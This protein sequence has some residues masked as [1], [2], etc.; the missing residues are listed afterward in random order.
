MHTNRQEL[1]RTIQWTTPLTRELDEAA[2]AAIIDLCQSSHGTDFTRLF[3]FL[4]DDGWHVIGWLAGRPICHAVRTTRW[5]QPPG[6]EPLKTA[7][8]DAVSTAVEHQGKGL[9]SAA[10]RRLAALIF[11]ED[12]ALCAL[13]TDKAG[14]YTRLGWEVWP[15]PLGGRR[16]GAVIELPEA[17]GNVLILRTPLTPV[18]DTGGLLTIEDQGRF[19]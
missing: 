4:P 12:Y 15:G 10:M 18:L 3:T 8:V 2:R 6:D 19:W 9:G 16:D 13:E 7:Y 1:L 5:A 14:F 17:A 11:T